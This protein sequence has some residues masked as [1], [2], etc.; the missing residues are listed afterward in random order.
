[1]ILLGVYIFGSMRKYAINYI[2]EDTWFTEFVVI[3]VAVPIAEIACILGQTLIPS[4]P[5]ESSTWQSEGGCA[6]I[7]KADGNAPREEPDALFLDLEKGSRCYTKT[8]LLA[9]LET[10]KID[11][12][13]AALMDAHK[14]ALD[15]VAIRIIKCTMR[16][17]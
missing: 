9:N 3:S 15:L 8:L 14:A 11:D 13:M 17:C 7:A 1:M 4:L 2:G 16:V 5:M 10:R 6:S 12:D